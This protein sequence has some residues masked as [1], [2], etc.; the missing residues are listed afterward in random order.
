ML[1]LVLLNGLAFV[2]FPEHFEPADLGCYGAKMSGP[3]RGQ[4]SD[5][6]LVQLD[7]H[8]T[9]LCPMEWKWNGKPTPPDRKAPSLQTFGPYL[10]VMCDVVLVA[11]DTEW[12]RGELMEIEQI[13]CSYMD[14]SRV[15][16]RESPL[17][18]ILTPVQDFSLASI[19]VRMPVWCVSIMGLEM[20]MEGLWKREKGGTGHPN[21]GLARNF[22]CHL[23]ER[24]MCGPRALK[25]GDWMD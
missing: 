11:L 10:E 12:W 25:I 17:Q 21:M 20:E 22:G 2:L 18:V 1:P 4:L 3:V 24:L 13:K 16:C 8:A 19:M 23:Q 15:G 9:T 7:N 5:R 6:S 14:Q